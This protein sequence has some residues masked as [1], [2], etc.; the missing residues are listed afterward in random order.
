MSR[1]PKVFVVVLNWNGHAKTV[2]CVRSLQQITYPNHEILLV[3]NASTDGSADVLSA[4]F[5]QYSLIR[6][7]SNLGYAGGNNVG[8]RHALERQADYV[9]VLNNDTTVDPH[10]LEPLVSCAE[11]H[12]NAGI[13]GGKVYLLGRPDLI[14]SAG[15]KIDLWFGRAYG[16]GHG[17]KDRGQFDSVREVEYLGGACILVSRRVFE[18]VG[19]LPTHYFMYYEETDFALC[20]RRAGF[21]IL[22]VPD[23]RIWHD[24]P[25]P[26]ALPDRMRL[27]H[28]TRSQ[29]MFIRRHASFLQRTVYLSYKLLVFFPRYWLE[30]VL[31]DPRLSRVLVRALKDGL[32]SPVPPLGHGP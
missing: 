10:F 30:L 31:R 22:Y 24:V 23:S 13:C 32:A 8:I 25:E 1:C 3:D 15:G 19:L 5:P 29:V 6:C 2:R 28:A 12:S 14:D 9:L 20:A 4:E 7:E 11:G 16:Y 27:Y 17:E 18:R 21:K 26:A